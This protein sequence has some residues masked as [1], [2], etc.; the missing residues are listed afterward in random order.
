M[1]ENP[2][3][4]RGGGFWIHFLMQSLNVKPQRPEERKA[5]QSISQNDGVTPGAPI[6]QKAA[7]WWRSLSL[8]GNIKYYTSEAACLT[9][10]TFDT[11]QPSAQTQNQPD[12]TQNCSP[13]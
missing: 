2:P 3:K 1:Q 13:M 8:K 12:K 11:L 7:S 4:K 6:E 9:E 5:C 10:C